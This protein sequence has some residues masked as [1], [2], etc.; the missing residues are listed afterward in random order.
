MKAQPASHQA[1]VWD[2]LITEFQSRLEALK[3]GPGKGELP[4]SWLPGTNGPKVAA[5]AA[6][7]RTVVQTMDEAII[8]LAN[9]RD[10]RLD[11][12]GL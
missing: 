1:N 4:A 7:L 6:S 9:W 2:D 10:Q 11:M 3:T 8:G 5:D 12:E